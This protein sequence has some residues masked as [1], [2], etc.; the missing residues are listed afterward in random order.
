MH[1][2]LSVAFHLL[3][4]APMWRRGALSRRGLSDRLGSDTDALQFH[5]AVRFS[6]FAKRRSRDI[7]NGNA[8][9][10]FAVEDSVVSMTVKNSGCAESINR[11]FQPAGAKKSINFRIFPLQRGTNR[12]VMEH[13]DSLFRLQLGKRLLQSNGVRDGFLHKLFNQRFAP[14]V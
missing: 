14:S 9:R 7:V 11:L 4:A 12:G 13:H 2:K 1:S 6:G 3:K 10:S 8:R 5:N